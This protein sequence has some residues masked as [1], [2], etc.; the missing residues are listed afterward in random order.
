[1][2]DH[3]RI[4]L[5]LRRS[6]EDV[7]LLEAWLARDGARAGAATRALGGVLSQADRELELLR[8]A[9][10]RPPVVGVVPA[11]PRAACD[12]VGRLL[13]RSAREARAQGPPHS[14]DIT[15]HL[16][17]RIGDG[18]AATALRL[19]AVA[20]PP[21]ADGHPVQL[22]LMSFADVAYLLARVAAWGWPEDLA[23]PLDLDALR[24]VYTDVG[25]SISTARTPGLSSRDIH[26]LRE[27]IEAAWPDAPFVRELAA[28]GYWSDLA[29]VVGHLPAAARISVLSLLWGA[30]P[31]LTAHATRLHDGLSRLGYAA[32]VSCASD[33]LLGIGSAAP[34]LGTSSAMQR[35][36]SAGDDVV[37]TVG[38]LG[39]RSTVSRAVL[40][41]LALEVVLPG[42]GHPLP[43]QPAA[44]LVVFPPVPVRDA[45]C[46]GARAAAIGPALVRA[47]A[48]LV[49]GAA[50]GTHD[51]TAL[52]AVIGPDA[53]GDDTL[54]DP[55]AEW[56][57][58]AQG[59]TPEA[60][61]NAPTG[62]FVVAPASL[63]ARATSGR[64]A[65][66]D[67]VATAIVDGIGADHA[68]PRE[69]TPGEPFS[70]VHWYGDGGR[71]PIVEPTLSSSLDL[72]PSD[73]A[74]ATSLSAYDERRRPRT[75]SETAAETVPIG[76]WASDSGIGAIADAI[77][78]LARPE[79]RAD[80]I[81]RRLV[82]IRRDLRGRL[83]RRGLESDADE[84]AAFRR[85]A[86][87][88]LKTRL[89]SSARAGRL[90]ALIGT[91]SLQ[92]GEARALAGKVAR[93]GAGDGPGWQTVTP[94]GT[95][96]E[97]AMDQR[98]AAD[99][100]AHW[101]A[102]LH[103]RA[104]C[105]SLARAAGI[106]ERHLSDLADELALAADR[107][108]LV[109][110]LATELHRGRADRWSP[111]SPAALAATASMVVSTFLERLAP[112][113][114]TGTL[115]SRNALPAIATSPLVPRAAVD[116]RIA[117]APLSSTWPAGVRALVDANAAIGRDRPLAETTPEL[118]GAFAPSPLESME[119]GL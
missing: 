110:E 23:R 15:A 28:C 64:G 59:T 71:S 41:V 46:P 67:A 81:R 52:V 58:R 3:Q 95:G 93:Q 77:A 39:H 19:P 89:R 5:L 79:D 60:R 86:A 74:G 31:E 107:Y 76:R 1:M 18:T 108:D 48:E 32:E 116:A 7:A 54:A 98:F 53:S 43:R 119:T 24:D 8:S 36:A 21:A 2:N 88:A 85:R 70:N 14:R 96:S 51:V 103:R 91:L 80:Q 92:P 47:K 106:P 111:A 35:L 45:P 68:W 84:V 44:D 37:R 22:R 40:S 57:D 104:Q 83:M 56:I 11:D 20:P 34:P 42:S 73:R 99:V 117:A 12:F 87:I 33:T 29:E 13:E 16:V 105:P 61:G 6:A 49:L 63:A 50:I 82:G 113:G 17:A 65:S 75:L 78:A 101:S 38:R 66:A 72:T 27:R 114:T 26:A 118:A 97:V 115:R 4:G 9:L 109:N 94:D 62:I 102:A 10:A 69:W 55:I 90:G 30:R 112:P 100:I 25:R